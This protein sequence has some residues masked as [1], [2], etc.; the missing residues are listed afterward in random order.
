MF[1]FINQIILLISQE[2]MSYLQ[3]TSFKELSLPDLKG[4]K[5]ENTLIY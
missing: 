1:V 2:N 4:V 5:Y 3:I